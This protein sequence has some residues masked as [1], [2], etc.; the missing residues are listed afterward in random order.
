MKRFIIFLLSVLTLSVSSAQKQS[1]LLWKISG[2]NLKKPSY[3]FGTFH[4]LCA[5]DLQLPDTLQSIIHQSKQVFFEIKMDDPDMYR[6]VQ[7][8]IVMKDGHKLND[9]ISAKDYDSLSAFFQNKTKIPL[10]FVATYKPYLLVP[11][12]YQSMLGCTP[13]AFELELQKI[14]KKDSTPVYGL[15]TV[16]FQMQLFDSIPYE[17]QAKMLLKNLYEFEQSKKDLQKMVAVYKRKNIEEIKNSVK[18]DKDFNKYEEVL[19]TSRNR[20]WIPLIA[21]A[22]YLMPSFFAVGAGHLGGE[23]GVLNLLQQKG[24]TITP[25]MY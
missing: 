18:N 17:Q 6:K 9:F 20:N 5:D 8:I 4:L 3:I 2:K 13:I 1:S 16:E 22:A 7:K 21:N 25:V 11:L 10:N 24:Y 12:L 14:S 15:E 23:N 19:L